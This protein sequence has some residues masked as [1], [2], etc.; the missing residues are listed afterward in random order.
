MAQRP[1]ASFAQTLKAVGASFFGVRGS[2]AHQTDL[3]TLNPVHVI[4][5][6]VAMAVLFVL[7]LILIVRMVTS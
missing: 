6:G 5:A 1:T 4:I 2:R 3:R 7:T